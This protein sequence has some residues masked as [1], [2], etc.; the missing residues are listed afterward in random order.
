MP[1][2]LNL[3]RGVSLEQVEHLGLSEEVDVLEVT[4]VSD[5]ER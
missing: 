2:T 3:E 4:F 5:V 1:D